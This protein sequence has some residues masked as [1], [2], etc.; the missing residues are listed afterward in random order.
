MKTI[1]SVNPSLS[2]K[3]SSK[4]IR[5]QSSKPSTK[6][7]DN[8]R[9]KTQSDLYPKGFVYKPKV[10]EKFL[11]E[12][13]NFPTFHGNVWVSY[14]KLSSVWLL[15]TNKAMAGLDPS[16]S[17]IR[18]RLCNQISA[19]GT[20]AGLFLV[21]A[22]AGFLAP[23]GIYKNKFNSFILTFFF[24]DY[25]KEEDK[26]LV[27]TYGCMMFTASACL[28]LYIN[29]TLTSLYPLIQSTRD[30]VAFDAFE[31]YAKRWGGYEMYLFMMG[32]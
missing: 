1:S 4:S 25:T 17:T 11:E 18:E 16:S 31:V 6:N 29:V 3:P 30:D 23:P 21:I 14:M 20:A 19:L 7:L 24:S 2:A 27:D 22:V 28:F 5:S 32:F 13:L 10:S 15:W 12:W 9:L 8:L 26:I